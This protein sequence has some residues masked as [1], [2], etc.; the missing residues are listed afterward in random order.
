M[1]HLPHS[2]LV[3]TAF[4][5]LSSLT[6][7]ARAIA[8]RHESFEGFISGIRANAVEGQVIYQRN[9]GKFDIEPGLK[10]EEGN[11]IRSGANAY[12]EVL[13]QPGNYLRVGEATECQILSGDHDRIRIRLL[14]GAISLE[15]LS[16]EFEGSMSFFDSLTTL[17]S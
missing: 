1:I 12:A 3:V 10:L 13:L 5:L 8:Q 2:L 14:R 4:A 16:N 17:M 9:D 7:S 11:V 15:I 6:N